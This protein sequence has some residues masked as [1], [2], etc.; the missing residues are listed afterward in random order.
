MCI[1]SRG[2]HACMLPGLQRRMMQHVARG[3]RTLPLFNFTPSPQSSSNNNVSSLFLD[4]SVPFLYRLDSKPRWAY[5]CLIPKAGSTAWKGVLIRGLTEQGFRM[6]TSPWNEHGTVEPGV[7][8]EHGQ[9]LPYNIPRLH[10]GAPVARLMIVRHPLA[11]LLSAYLGK[12]ASGRIRGG[13]SNESGFPGFARYIMAVPRASS[14]D[15]HFR[16]QVDQCGVRNGLRYEYLRI[17]EIGRWFRRVVC[18]LG[19]QSAVSRPWPLEGKLLVVGNSSAPGCFVSTLDCGCEL[20]CG[21]TR[22][23]ASVGVYDEAVHSSF[24]NAKAELDRYY[25]LALARAVNAWAADDLKT[26]GYSPWWPG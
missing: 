8:W 14:L 22:C 19:L 12:V 10:W 13:W 11:R 17:E 4:D 18:M 2:K 23:N 7:R 1:A 3:E 26:F 5:L 16:L 9:P 20:T 25:D 21:G 24:R 6:D 15:P